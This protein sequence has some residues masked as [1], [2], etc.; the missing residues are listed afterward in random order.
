[1]AEAVLEKRGD[2][3]RLLKGFFLDLPTDV[4]ETNQHHYIILCVITYFA[5]IA[6]TSWIPL[7]G[8]LV[9][10]RL[11]VYHFRS[12]KVDHTPSFSDRCL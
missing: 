4:K 3:V 12:L 6:H 2:F 11:K 1:M 5:F 8:I 9:N 10:G 7:F